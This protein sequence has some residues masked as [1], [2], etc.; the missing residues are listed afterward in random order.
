VFPEPEQMKQEL[1]WRLAAWPESLSGVATVDDFA[2]A[3]AA[4][5]FSD[6]ECYRQALT[7]WFHVGRPTCLGDLCRKDRARAAAFVKARRAQE[8]RVANVESRLA[9]LKAKEA[10]PHMLQCMTA[11][12]FHEHEV[13]E[14]IRQAVSLCR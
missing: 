7:E 3:L 5:I 12:L 10:P 8:K 14:E 6:L 13:L 11:T 2:E 1:R 9:F 4:T